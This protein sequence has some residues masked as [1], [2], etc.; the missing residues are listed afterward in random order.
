MSNNCVVSAAGA[1]RGLVTLHGHGAVD[2]A[3]SGLP[4]PAG[5]CV[6][7]ARQHPSAQPLPGR[8]RLQ[9]TPQVS[10]LFQPEVRIF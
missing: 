5:A 3:G 6:R 8:G 2:R 7:A 4:R 9:P 1:A 10:H